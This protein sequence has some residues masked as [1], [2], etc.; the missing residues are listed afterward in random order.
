M[1]YVGET[2]IFQKEGTGIAISCI[3]SKRG[4]TEDTLWLFLLREK[5]VALE[6][7]EKQ[8]RANSI[9]SKK[10]LPPKALKIM[11]D[12]ARTCFNKQKKD[13]S[14]WE[15]HIKCP[16]PVLTM[17]KTI[18]KPVRAAQKCP[19]R[20]FTTLQGLAIDMPVESP[21]PTFE[22][23]LQSVLANAALASRISATMEAAKWF[24]REKAE[25]LKGLDAEKYYNE[26]SET[27]KQLYQAQIAGASSDERSSFGTLATVC[28][29]L[30]LHPE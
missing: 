15:A 19:R 2:Y 29:T 10:A 26:V 7:R 9:V 12:E 14:K 28:S 8:L 17:K 1:P 18:A 11:L 22:G 21:L 30:T 6:I 24:A 5:G 25:E 13:F 20:T 23:L 27:I 3:P 4:S 16:G